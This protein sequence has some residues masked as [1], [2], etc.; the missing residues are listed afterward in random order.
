M[1]KGVETDIDSLALHHH[2]NCSFGFYSTPLE[3]GL[4]LSPE[5]LEGRLYLIGSILRSMCAVPRSAVCFFFSCI[6][7]NYT[8]ES[9]CVASTFCL[10]ATS[11]NRNFLCS[12][13]EENDFKVC[14]L[15]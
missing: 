9:L 5:A 6:A 10:G 14:G 7:A 4:I 11:T 13:L 15:K 1:L 2:H 12:I 8:S 3:P